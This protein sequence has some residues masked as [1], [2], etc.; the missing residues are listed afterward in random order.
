VRELSANGFVVPGIERLNTGPTTN[1]EVRYF[2]RSEEREATDIA[3]ILLKGG[4]QKV[5]ATYVPGYGNS[6]KIRS[7]HFEIWFAPGAFHE[8][9]G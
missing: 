8:P 9:M 2:R 1:T 4:L 7:R 6:T 5:L 3:S